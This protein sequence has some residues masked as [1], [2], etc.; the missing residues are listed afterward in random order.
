MAVAVIVGVCAGS[1][2]GRHFTIPYTTAARPHGPSHQSRPAASEADRSPNARVRPSH[3]P[4]PAP[5]RDQPAEP[6]QTATVTPE[7]PPPPPRESPKPKHRRRTSGYAG[8]IA[9][10]DSASMVALTFD[11]GA[12]GAPTPAV[13]DALKSAGLHVTFFLTGKWC[14]RNE[15]LVK[16]IH[17]GGHE[18]A[19]HTYS[20]PDLRELT[21]EAIKE[22]IEK[23]DEIVLRITG[24]HCAPYLRPPYGGR[25]K[26]VI[27]IASEAGNRTVYWSLDS[28][29]SFKKG[30]T[31]R[32]IRER[33]LDRVQGGDVVLLHCGSQA[34]ADALPELIRELEAR[35]YR[36]VTVSEM[37]AGP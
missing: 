27:R 17:D 18:I 23:T 9:H 28:W 7:K 16:R 24:E 31:S 29:D 35:G 37:V 14:E 33:V 19:N 1:Y 15:A 26:R 20:H 3:G 8:E 4:V 36:V 12:S 5:V 30:I 11:A 6:R 32:E 34:T 10:T 2:L 22:Q 21:D 25:D 13:L